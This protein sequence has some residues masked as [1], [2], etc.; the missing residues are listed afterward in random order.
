MTGF[1]GDRLGVG[2]LAIDV[3][4]ARR[5]E[6]QMAEFVS[7]ASHELRTPLTGVLGF[8]HLL[9]EELEGTE[10]AAWAQHIIAES[11]RLSATVSDLLNAAR[12]EGGLRFAMEPVDLGRLL[13]RAVSA[14]RGS[15]ERSIELQAE[16]DLWVTGDEA[17]L[18]EVVDNLVSNA[19]KYSPPGSSVT[20][21]ASHEGHGVEV[22][23]RDRGYGIAEEDLPLVFERYFR[24]ARTSSEVRGTGLG[25]HIV[26][27]F[28]R[29]MGGRVSVESAPGVGSEFTVW[30]P[31]IE[32]DSAAA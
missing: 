28:L 31:S 12:L 19:L 23:V 3:S 17:R 29:E 26:R 24:G 5:A 15:E 13:A 7:I 32:V 20:V 30:L 27:E 1:L 14:A 18:R 16:V 22:C 25:L 21:L 10:Q 4:A 6:R 11:E 8:A 9:A 2:L